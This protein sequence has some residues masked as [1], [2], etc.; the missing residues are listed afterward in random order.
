MMNA[1]VSPGFQVYEPK[2]L[3]HTDHKFKHIDG[4]MR[5]KIKIEIKFLVLAIFARACQNDVS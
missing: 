2:L 5:M 1:Y 3:K 4:F